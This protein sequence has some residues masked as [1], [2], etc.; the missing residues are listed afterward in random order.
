MKRFSYFFFYS[1]F[2]LLLSLM[3]PRSIFAT[4]SC[5]ASVNINET[6]YGQGATISYS[7]TD[8]LGGNTDLYLV[9][10]Q[11]G[12]Q[13]YPPLTLTESNYKGRYYYKV[14]SCTS[15]QSCQANTP[16]DLPPGK[17][18]V[19]CSILTSPNA[20]SGNPFCSYEGEGGNVNC[21]ALTF[22]SCS[23]TDKAFFTVK[24]TTSTS[25]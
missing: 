1:F 18:F 19:Y 2:L 4:K 22:G 10:W 13:I 16:A 7:G 17:Y 15:G 14:A 25:V 12:E 24:P 21:E 6:T 3:T 5:T 11:D 9:R 23:T 20:C 8:D